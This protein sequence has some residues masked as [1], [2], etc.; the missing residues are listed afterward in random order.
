[1]NKRMVLL[2]FFALLL[3][4]PCLAMAEGPKDLTASLALL[5]GVIDGPDKG[6]FVDLVKALQEYT[7]GKITIAT[8]PFARSMDNVIKGKADF[9]IPSVRNP[10]I[11]HDPSLPWRFATEKIGQAAFVIYSSPEKPVTRKMIVEAMAK[12]GK[13]PYSIELV[14]GIE[15]TFGCPGTA[16]IDLPSS[17]QKVAKKRLDALI[18]A[19]EEADNVV[20]NLKLKNVHRELYQVYDDHPI[21]A[22][23]AHGDEV[24][25]ML[26]AAIK[27]FRASGKLQQYYIKVHHPY[28]DWQPA[29]MDW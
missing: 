26:S 19:Q 6:P 3:C 8:F 2:A 23:G 27:K 14:P 10:S 1:M 29:N 18:W 5:P 21:V 7:G 25:R 13:F 4:A 15:A 11:R 28:E 12:G 24:D 22:K 9:H 20:R 16:S 17:L